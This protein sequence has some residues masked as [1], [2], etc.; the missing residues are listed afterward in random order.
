MKNDLIPFEGYKLCCTYD[1]AIEIWYFS[2]IDIIQSRIN[3][4]FKQLENSRKFLK[5]G[6][7]KKS[8][9]S[10][11]KRNQLKLEASDG[12]KFSNKGC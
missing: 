10:V 9:E 3:H 2:V 12:E 1:K 11:I 4:I 7:L 5:I 8:S 6:S